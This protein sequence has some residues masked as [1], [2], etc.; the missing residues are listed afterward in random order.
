MEQIITNA[1]NATYKC[2]VAGNV[3]G[4]LVNSNTITI[5]PDYQAEVD[6]TENT[7]PDDVTV[8]AK[9]FL[10]ESRV[11]MIY[12]VNTKKKHYI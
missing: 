7:K 10:E 6:S 11:G 8:N 2:Q 3:Y 12:Y 5:Y 4:S 1:A 9:I